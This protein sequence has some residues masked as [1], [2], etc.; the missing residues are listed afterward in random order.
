M[1]SEFNSK[2]PLH[3]VTQHNIPEECEHY[4]SCCWLLFELLFDRWWLVFPF[5]TLAFALWLIMVDQYSVTSDSTTQKCITF[6]M[7]PA[8]KSVTDIQKVKPVL[9]HE[10][11]QN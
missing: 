4:F 3:L 10:L 9:F 1:S 8:Q 2:L 6:Q 7:I 11:F 5:H